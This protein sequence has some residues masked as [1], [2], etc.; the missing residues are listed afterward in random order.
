MFPLLVC[1][2]RSMSLAK[3]IRASFVFAI[4]TWL[5]QTPE[6]VEK[7]GA[8]AWMSVGM[9]RKFMPSSYLLVVKHHIG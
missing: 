2:L 7:S 8:P 4:Q 6:Q 1:S 3:E 5:A 9:S